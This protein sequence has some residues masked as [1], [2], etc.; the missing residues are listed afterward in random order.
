M[1]RRNGFAAALGLG[2]LIAGL[3]TVAGSPAPVA[4]AQRTASIR[5]WN[6]NISGSKMHKGSITDGVV[7]V[8]VASIRNRAVDFA[9]FNEIC[10]GQ[11]NAIINA[12]ADANWPV[13]KTNFSRFT[14]SA[15]ASKGWCRSGEDF[16]NAIIAKK[17]LANAQRWTLPADGSA[18][19]RT[20]TCV[21]PTDTPE[22]RYCT[23]HITTDQSANVAQ[24]NFVLAQMESFRTAGVTALIGGDFNAQPSYG[25][26]NNWYSS[27]LNVT[28]NGSNT[29][30]Y[31]ELDD[32][33]SGNCLG[34]GEWT[35][36]GTPGTAPPCASSQPLSKIDLMFVRQDRLAGAYSGDSLSIATSCPNAIE[37][38]GV[39]AGSCSDHRILIGTVPIL[40]G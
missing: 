1:R 16:G 33:D 34:Y 18:E 5:L 30:Q 8:A 38:A 13:D 26:L 14:P 22:M 28:A 17:P 20:L 15:P 4:A 32:N 36:L 12:L 29:G 24:L 11:Y 31:R 9:S 27:S 40:L 7:D 39:P 10:H 23:T 37:P 25:R 21:Y 6:W 2:V 19:D 3:L 35:A